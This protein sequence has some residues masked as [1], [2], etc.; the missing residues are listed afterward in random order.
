MRAVILAGQEC[1]SDAQ[2]AALLAYVRGGGTLVIAG[3]TGQ[4]D[5]WREVRSKNP[6]LP[7][8]T[9]GKGK[10]VLIPEVIR[11][12]KQARGDGGGRES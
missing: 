1:I 6:M 11:A 2:V 10:I 9:E 4:Y 3:N 8:R 5:Q 12:D 7:A